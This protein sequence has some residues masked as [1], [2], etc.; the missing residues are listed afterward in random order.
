M[1]F[2]YLYKYFLIAMSKFMLGKRH[3]ATY[4]QVLG[5]QPAMFADGLTALCVICIYLQLVQRDMGWAAAC[6]CKHG[7]TRW[8]CA[9]CPLS[10]CVYMH[11][12]SS[13]RKPIYIILYIFMYVTIAAHGRHP[14]LSYMHPA[15]N[16][17]NLAIQAAAEKPQLRTMWSIIGTI[18]PRPPAN[19]KRAISR[20]RRELLN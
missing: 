1:Q 20:R 7:G 15:A 16:A 9:V 17:N 13:S 11:V 10:L 2:M 8:P 12:C 6:S 14:H 3:Y 19:C 5:W 18:S 4:I